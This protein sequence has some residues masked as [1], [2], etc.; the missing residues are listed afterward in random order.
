MIVLGDICTVNLSRLIASHKYALW[1]SVKAVYLFILFVFLGP[2]WWHMEVSKGSNW[3]CNRGP[4]PK[5]C[6]I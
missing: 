6:Q 2:H 5:Q 3:S 4:M 1:C